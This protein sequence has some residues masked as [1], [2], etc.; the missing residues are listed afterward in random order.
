MKRYVVNPK[1]LKKCQVKLSKHNNKVEVK[2]TGQ[3]IH[4]QVMG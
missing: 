2:I 4:W 1:A 3:G